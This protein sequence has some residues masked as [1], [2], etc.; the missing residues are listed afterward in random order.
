MFSFRWALLAAAAGCMVHAEVRPVPP[1]GIA[2][3]ETDRVQLR[4]GLDQLQKSIDSLGGNALLADVLI[5][6]KAVRYALDGNEF[7]KPEEIG[8]AKALLA[9]GLARAD[10]LRNG[11]APW[12]EATGL[13]VRGY[14][15]KID[16][17]VQPYGLVV[18]P[19]WTPHSTNSWR[20]DTW[21]HGRGE[22]L[23]EV[24]FL[25]DRERNPGEFTPPGAIVLHLYG[26][27]CNASKFAGETDFFEALAD[28]KA[29][30]RIDERRIVIRGFS[31]GGASA[32]QFA[33]HY[34]GLWAAAAPGAG[35][36]ETPE[37]VHLREQK[38]P[39][40]LQ[41]WEEKLWHWTNSTDYAANLY[42]CPLVAYNGDQDPQ[43]QAAD[44]MERALSEEGMRLA[45]VTGLGAG[46][47]YTPEAKQTLNERIDS[48][49][50][51]GNDPT[52]GMVRFT[53][54]TLSYNQMKWV[55][56]DG[57]KEHWVRARVNAEMVDGHSVRVETANVSALT[58]AM[59]AGTCPL[60]AASVVTLSVDGTELRVPGPLTDRS[61]SA[62]LHQESGK[63]KAGAGDPTALRKRHGLQGPID[64]AFTDSFLIVRPTGEAASARF[65][66][67]C[68]SEMARAI[69]EWR[70]E[71]RGDARVKN[72]TEVTDADIAANNLILWGD[73]ASNRLL[74][75][76][77]KQLP[78]AWP[79]D[80]NRALI[81]IFPNPL[82]PKRYV[83]LNSG[84]TFREQQYLN[85]AWQVA[86][87]PD[88]AIVDLTT[89]PD[90]NWPGRIADAG[91]FDEDWRLPR[92][93]PR[94]GE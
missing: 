13:I 78:M 50:E 42:Q 90:E 85:N 3:P 27:Y 36:A 92:S 34:A 21:F 52:P 60:D 71:F 57:L 25:S 15:S 73:P 10:A 26:R 83:V 33:T 54:W 11:Q 67:W 9:E 55:T 4:T 56:I 70:R 24:N 37:F 19:G 28:V 69:R 74:A 16:G 87:L 45:R 32:W 82:N 29:H 47:K 41:P 23:S 7:F 38:P 81:L 86:R 75:R 51:R 88:W 20:L 80:P 76:I 43:R 59:A 17:S 5:F 31:M 40:L 44:V 8:R 91:F 35:F 63:W 30:Y 66:T 84:F 48:M 72:D 46:H 64:D 77:A 6:H 18:P 22:T 53:T 14:I 2:V 12:T 79:A 65:G 62:S 39:Y 49:A 1:P 89:P 58:L 93:A 94:R 61:W 68:A